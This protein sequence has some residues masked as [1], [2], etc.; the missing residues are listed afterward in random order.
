MLAP[1]STGQHRAAPASTGQH[2]PAPA[3]TGQHR[4]APALHMLSFENF[5]KSMPPSLSELKVTPSFCFAFKIP[6]DVAASNNYIRNLSIRI[7]HGFVFYA[8]LRYILM[9]LFDMNL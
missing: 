6:D 2:R 4:P 8:S 1:A 5:V 9:L 3:S 7:P